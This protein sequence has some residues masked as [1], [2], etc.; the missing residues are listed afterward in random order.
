MSKTHRH[1]EV[2][3]IGAGIV[4]ISVAYYLAVKYGVARIALIDQRDPMSLTSAQSGENYRNWWP[5][6]VMKSFTDDSTELMERIARDSGNAIAMTRRGYALVTRRQNPSDLLQELRRAYGED[7]RFHDGHSASAAYARSSSA[8]EEAPSGVDVLSGPNLIRDV[9]PAYADDVRTVLHIRRAG[10]I[11]GQQLGQYMLEELRAKGGGLVRAKVISIDAGKPFSLELRTGSETQ[12]I[13]A[14]KVVNAAGPFVSDVAR[15]LEVDLPVE[16]VF[17]QKISFEDRLAVVPRD[18][19]F[20]IDLDP[21]TLAWSEEDREILL[22]DPEARKFT[23]TMIGGIHCRPDGPYDGAWIKLGWAYNKSPTEPHLEDPI[24]P[25]F[26]DIVLRGASRL[27]PG[28]AK[29]IGRLPRNAHHYGGYYTMTKENWPLIGPSGPEGAF[30]A[31]ALS[32][33]GTM[34][35]CMSGSICADWVMGGELVPY[36]K[37]LTTDRYSEPD[38]AAD[39]SGGSRGLL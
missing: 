16:N 11:S 32:G 34:A 1:Y 17:Q 25:Q 10:S 3:V 33:F 21:Q 12:T 30:V 14:D 26:P 4:G 19:P 38:F 18:L 22:G 6:T 35:A 31:G 29:Y 28:L 15:M 39:L 8:W 36:A 24:D 13:V 9:F 37:I 7:V 27:Q 2:A 20:T 23:E 5:D